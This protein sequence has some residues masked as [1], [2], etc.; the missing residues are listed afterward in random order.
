MLKLLR[1]FLR[2][3]LT[4]YRSVSAEEKAKGVRQAGL[5]QRLAAG[6]GRGSRASRAQ[7][8]TQ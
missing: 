1:Q 8:R 7:I 4:L 6:G 3:M 5:G 2:L